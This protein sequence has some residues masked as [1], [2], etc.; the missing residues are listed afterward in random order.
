[1]ERCCKSVSFTSDI[2]EVT[3]DACKCHVYNREEDLQ[4]GTILLSAYVEK[5]DDT[6]VERRGNQIIIIR[7]EGTPVRC[8]Q[9]DI[10]K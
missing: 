8:S 5:E 9:L 10:E 7:K 4:K 6:T 2:P 1:M 3:I